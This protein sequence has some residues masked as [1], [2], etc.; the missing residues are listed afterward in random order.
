MT[1][2]QGVLIDPVYILPREERKENVQ[3]VTVDGGQ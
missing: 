1:G 2:I 3:S